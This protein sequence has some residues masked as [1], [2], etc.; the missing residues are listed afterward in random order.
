[1]GR[2]GRGGGEKEPG[3]DNIG[4]PSLVT[5]DSDSMTREGGEEPCSVTGAGTSA[6]RGAVSKTGDALV[7]TAW[8]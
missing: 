1:M 4:E 3:G 2:P 7:S 8:D 6:V 5:G